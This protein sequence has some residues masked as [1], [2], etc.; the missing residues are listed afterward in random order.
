MSSWHFIRSFKTI[1]GIS[2]HQYVLQQRIKKAQ[3]LLQQNQISISEIAATVGFCDQSH[4]TKYFKRIVGITPR[5][6]R[7]NI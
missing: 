6:Y 5:Q 3:Y 4:F 2:P 7:D 1:T